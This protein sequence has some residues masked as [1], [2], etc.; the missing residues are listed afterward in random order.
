MPR[1]GTVVSTP[2]SVAIPAACG[3]MAKEVPMA[4]DAAAM[5]GEMAHDDMAMD[6]DTASTP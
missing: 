6:E 5:E 1:G 3:Q 2:F 4:A